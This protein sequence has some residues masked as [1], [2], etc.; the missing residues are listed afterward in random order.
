MTAAI[1]TIHHAIESRFSTLISAGGDGGS[2]VPTLFGNDNA[3]HP[4]SGTW[5]RVT[6]SQAARDRRDT[7][8]AAV[9]SRTVGVLLVE[10]FAEIGTGTQAILDLADRVLVAF[11]SEH[12]SGITYRTPRIQGAS[13]P[14]RFGKWARV[15]VECPFFADDLTS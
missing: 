10:L 5:A 1:S 2:S 13:T 7:G 8:A 14:D 9:R 3:A 4:E 12:A 15:T 11:D 6:I